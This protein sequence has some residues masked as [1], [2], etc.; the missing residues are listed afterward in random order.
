MNVT[1]HVH[2]SVVLTMNICHNVV[3]TV[4]IYHNVVLIAKKVGCSANP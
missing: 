3:L 2:Y 1:Y 4:N